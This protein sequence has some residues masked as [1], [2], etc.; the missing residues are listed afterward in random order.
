M[1]T[2][3]ITI[4]VIVLA[5]AGA[6]LA[7]PVAAQPKDPSG[8]RGP[9]SQQRGC[10]SR[11]SFGDPIIETCRSESPEPSTNQ[12]VSWRPAAT[13]NPLRTPEN[14]TGVGLEPRSVPAAHDDDPADIE[15]NHL[16]PPATQSHQE[17]T[18]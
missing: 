14:A 18:V 2:N 13:W 4:V 16:Q 1:K 12:S 17:K 5:V 9:P 6:L 10:Q 15:M 11:A 8:F 7:M 3:L